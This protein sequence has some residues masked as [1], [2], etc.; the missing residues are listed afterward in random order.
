MAG[1]LN[2]TMLKMKLKLF[3]G[4]D[5]ESKKFQISQID[6]HFIVHQKG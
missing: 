2:F 6:F 3:S 1:I 4:S 5:P